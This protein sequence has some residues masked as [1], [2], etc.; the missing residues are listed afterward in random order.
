MAQNFDDATTR[1]MVGIHRILTGNDDVGLSEVNFA[2]RLDPTLPDWMRL[3]RFVAEYARISD[4]DRL[5]GI[6]REPRRLDPGPLSILYRVLVCGAAK[7]ENGNLQVSNGDCTDI[8][9]LIREL[10]EAWPDTRSTADIARRLERLRLS[11]TRIGWLV[12]HLNAV[13]F[14]AA[15][16]SP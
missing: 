4:V 8:D 9:E 6:Y 1:G 14:D 12:S 15:L 5:R 3:A 13:D 2:L 11:P 7:L 16:S 10:Q